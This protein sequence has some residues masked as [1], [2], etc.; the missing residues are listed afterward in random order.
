MIKNL[1]RNIS[2][3]QQEHMKL[4]HTN[5]QVSVS[6]LVRDVE[7]ERPKF[8]PLQANTVEE[9]E[10]EQKPLEGLHFGVFGVEEV[11]ELWHLVQ[12][13]SQQVSL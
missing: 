12:V 4:W 3:L 2:V 13:G 1:E 7:A 5:P 6:K 11:V 10:R 9:A 8:A